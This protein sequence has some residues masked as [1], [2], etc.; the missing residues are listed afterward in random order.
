MLELQVNSETSRGG[1][2]GQCRLERY[3][4]WAIAEFTAVYEIE[5]EF[6][7]LIAAQCERIAADV[8]DHEV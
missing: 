4:R 5:A 6:N 3:D 7:K 8:V 1:R 2:G